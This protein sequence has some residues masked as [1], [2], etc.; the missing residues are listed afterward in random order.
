MR[1]VKNECLSNGPMS[2]SD[3]ERYVLGF[4]RCSGCGRCFKVRNANKPEVTI[5]RHSR[6]ARKGGR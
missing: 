6:D 3:H 4:V 5:P 1:D 2:A